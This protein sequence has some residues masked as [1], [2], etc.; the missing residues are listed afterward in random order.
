MYIDNIFNVTPNMDFSDTC[1][2]PI[3]LSGDTEY[4]VEQTIKYKEKGA[5]IVAITNTNECS[6][7]R[8]A[9]ESFCHYF[10]EEFYNN[11]NITSHIPTIFILE[12]LGKK[13][14]DIKNLEGEL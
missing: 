1:I 3:S 6:L 5:Y 4:I 13:I 8:C 7:V 10:N 14:R 12:S 11:N 9:H 2:I